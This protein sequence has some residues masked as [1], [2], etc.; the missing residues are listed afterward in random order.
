MGKALVGIRDKVLVTTKIGR[1]GRRTGQMVPMTTTDMVRLCV[2]ASLYRLKTGYVDIMLCHEGKLDDPQMADTYLDGF[3]LLQQQGLIRTY[4]ISTDRLAVLKLFNSRGTCR[5]VETDYSLL[6]RSADKA[7]LPYCQE[8]GIAVLARGPLHKGL[9]SG[10]YSA[11]T[12]FTDTVRSEWYKNEKSKAKLARK[13]E[14]VEK[15]KTAVSP[16]AD[17]VKAALRFV[18]SHPIAPVAI[19]GAKSPE[20]VV[21]NADAGAQL[22][23]ADERGHLI[24]FTKLKDPALAIT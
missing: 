23:S 3:D 16:G 11:Q 20:Q 14:K 24:Q 8:H 4:G 22:L 12:V 15:L 2:H 17:M 13:L 7:F 9:L 18:I 6:N 10:K 1:W 19:A 5:V 21:I